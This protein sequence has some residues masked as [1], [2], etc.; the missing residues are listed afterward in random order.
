M[1]VCGILIVEVKSTLYSWLLVLLGVLYYGNLYFCFP[2]KAKRFILFCLQPYDN[3]VQLSVRLSSKFVRQ[4]FFL[5]RPNGTFF[6]IAWHVIFVSFRVF[7]LLL[8][9]EKSQCPKIAYKPLEDIIVYKELITS[10]LSQLRW[11]LTFS[12]ISSR[13]NVKM[14]GRRTQE[15]CVFS[16]SS[17]LGTGVSSF[18]QPWL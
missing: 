12:C 17:Q 16:V 14:E 5:L 1:A 18:N 11:T 6:F 8:F 7:L 10:T 13:K 15:T 3:N 9:N 4:L 2:S